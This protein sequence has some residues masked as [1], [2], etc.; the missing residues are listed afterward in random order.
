[1]E[2]LVAQLGI[3]GLLKSQVSEMAKQLDAQ[4]FRNGPLDAGSYTFV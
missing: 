1:V 4:T 3:T 2:K